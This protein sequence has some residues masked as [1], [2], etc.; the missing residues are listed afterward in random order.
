MEVVRFF[1]KQEWDYKTS[2]VCRECF[3]AFSILL[4][5]DL[6]STPVIVPLNPAASHC[7]LDSGETRALSSCSLSW[8]LVPKEDVNTVN[9]SAKEADGVGHFRGNVLEAEE[10]VG[11]LRRASHL[12]GT[13][14]AQHKQ[15]H[16]Q[17]I[18]LDD[19]GSKLQS[20]DDPIG[21]GVVHVLGWGTEKMAVSGDTKH[22]ALG[23]H[24]LKAVHLTQKE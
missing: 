12:A 19:E 18:I 2:A 5:Q 15:V 1:N 3:T 10:I 17:A 6:L 4:T 7:L 11:H 22:M 13:M 23:T 16:H 14:Q 20:P 8:P 9:V 21:V 24:S